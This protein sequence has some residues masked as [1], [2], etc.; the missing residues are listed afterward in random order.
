MQLS[1]LGQ[2][3]VDSGGL[4]LVINPAPKTGPD[5]HETFVGDVDDGVAFEF[6]VDR[7]H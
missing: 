7:R 5:A 2:T 6:A 1:G 4:S 3:E